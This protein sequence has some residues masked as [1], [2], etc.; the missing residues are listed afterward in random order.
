MSIANPEAQTLTMKQRSFI[1]VLGILS[2]LLA[3]LMLFYLSPAEET[4]KA[5]AGPHLSP[6]VYEGLVR[7]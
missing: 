6:A 2:V 4:S 1:G 3:T 7:A 5:L